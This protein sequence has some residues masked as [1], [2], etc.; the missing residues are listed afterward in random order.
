MKVTTMKMTQRK[1]R[2]TL[3]IRSTHRGNLAL[4]WSLMIRST[5]WPE[6]LWLKS[7]I[8]RSKRLKIRTQSRW[9]PAAKSLSPKRF[10]TS[11]PWK[12]SISRFKRANSCVSL[13]MWALARA[14][15]SSL[16]LATCFTWRM[17]STKFSKMS[18]ST[19]TSVRE[20]CSCPGK[21][22]KG[23]RLQLF[24]LRN[25][26]KETSKEMATEFWLTPRKY[27]GSKTRLSGT[28][29]YSVSLTMKSFT[30]P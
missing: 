16:W 26:S 10:K 18:R 1:S 28:I 19:N 4:I 27:L 8:C 7:S 20:S 12:A 5:Q 3:K 6:G 2:W 22:S 30:T 13:A 21:S 23:T 11:L 25:T 24:I 14:H 29:F 17:I 9:P 15:W